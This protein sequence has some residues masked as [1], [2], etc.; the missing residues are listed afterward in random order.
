MG[1]PVIKTEYLNTQFPS[2]REGVTSYRLSV[3]QVNVKEVSRQYY[4]G[5]YIS[6][7]LVFQ[8][9]SFVAIFKQFI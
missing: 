8:F 6:I 1:A 9:R 3:K 7:L 5:T 4:M 2:L